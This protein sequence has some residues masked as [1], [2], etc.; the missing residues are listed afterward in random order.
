MDGTATEGEDWRLGV[1]IRVTVES[2]VLEPGNRLGSWQGVPLACL[3]ANVLELAGE[4]RFKSTHTTI[5][6]AEADRSHCYIGLLLA[7]NR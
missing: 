2:Q 7:F 5:K 3:P 1:V 6:G 4:T